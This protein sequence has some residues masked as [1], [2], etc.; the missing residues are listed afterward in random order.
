MNIQDEGLKSNAIKLRI[1]YDEEKLTELAQ[2]RRAS[3]VQHMQQPEKFSYTNQAYNNQSPTRLSVVELKEFENKVYE[4]PE[5]SLNGEIDVENSSSISISSISTQKSKLD[6]L[7]ADDECLKIDIE[8]LETRKPTNLKQSSSLASLQTTR[9][10]ASRDSFSSIKNI[11]QGPFNSNSDKY[12]NDLYGLVE[13]T[14]D[15]QEDNTDI[16]EML[17][18]VERP[19]K[20]RRKTEFEI[21]VPVPSSANQE[22]CLFTKI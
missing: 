4:V 11:F 5:F 21:F 10:R 7:Q 16:D 8:L 18:I 17:T 20:K 2:K 12:D 14:D 1:N 13:D 6:M 19:S 22:N 9:Q 15:I 3:R